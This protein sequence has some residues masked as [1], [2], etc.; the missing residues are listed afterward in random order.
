[1]NIMTSLLITVIASFSISVATAQEGEANVKKGIPPD[2]KE[3]KVVFL[4]YDSTEVDAKDKKSS[5]YQKRHNK[6]VPDAN[7]EW[8]AAAKEYPYS[9][10]IA[11]RKDLDALKEKGYKYF[12]DC[13]ALR[14]MA[15]GTRNDKSTSTAILANYYTIYFQE[16]G[17]TN[18]W[19]VSD[20]FNENQL[21]FPKFIMNKYV[22]KAIKK[23]GK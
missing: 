7:K 15:S 4:R 20:E 6:N 18:A 12:L 21:Y 3:S 14:N 16:I 19:V 5:Y 23:A 17:T 13:E 1:M 2:L 11:S 10:V 8:A 22:L 9:Y